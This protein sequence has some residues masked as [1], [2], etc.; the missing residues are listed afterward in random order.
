MRVVV[1]VKHAP[2]SDS[3]VR[4]GADGRSIDQRCLTYEVNE[5]DKYAVE[6]AVRLKEAYGGEVVAVS[7]G[8]DC[9]STLRRCLATGVDRALK[10]PLETGMDA[11]RTADAIRE[12]LKDVDFDLVLAG[13]MSQDLN[14]ALVGVLLAAMLGLPFATAVTSVRIEDSLV[15]AV[16]ELEGGYYEEV[17]LPLPCLL[18]VQSGINEPRYVSIM[19]IKA[20]R[21]KE[22]REVH[23]Q[24]VNPTLEVEKVYY[25]L[26]K[27]AELI[28][29]PP[30][31]VAEKI[32]VLL[33]DRG[34]IG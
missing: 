8:V 19:G 34:V 20:A 27:R 17:V 14:N 11:Y 23:V 24:T 29:G 7:V 13:F 15:R 9:D 31:E 18:T 28:E 16:R 32:A 1:L 33:R 3:E 2:S 12:A 30:S 4:V 21:A 6:E 10:V 22:L 25:P 26:V 5:W